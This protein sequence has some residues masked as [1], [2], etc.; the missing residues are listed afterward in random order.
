MKYY[1]GEEDFS[2]E[3]DSDDEQR[4]CGEERKVGSAGKPTSQL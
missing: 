4:G 2:Q 1:D 3:D